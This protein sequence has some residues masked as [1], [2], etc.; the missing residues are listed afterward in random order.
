MRRNAYYGF[1]NS[2]LRRYAGDSL[3]CMNNRSQLSK[4][5]LRKWSTALA[6]LFSLARSWESLTRSVG[7][8]SGA[9][10]NTRRSW[11]YRC[12]SG[13][14]MPSRL[15]FLQQISLIVSLSLAAYLGTGCSRDQWRRP[16]GCRE[17]CRWRRSLPWMFGTSFW[18]L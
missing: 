9:C 4:V 17:P 12:P 18:F 3:T 13:D 14:E 7:R 5:M 15:R 2:L 8:V 16:F 1:V 10:R 11:S 6:L